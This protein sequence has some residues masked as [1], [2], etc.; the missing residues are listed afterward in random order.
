MEFIDTLQQFNDFSLLANID[1][2]SILFSKNF[3]QIQHNRA[4]NVTNLPT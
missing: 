3:I 1:N 4:I 2:T